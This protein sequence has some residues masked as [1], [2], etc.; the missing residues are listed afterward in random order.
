MDYEIIRKTPDEL[1]YKDRGI[2]KWQ[3]FMLPE[4]LDALKKRKN[5]NKQGKQIAKELMTAQE[6]SK[7]LQQ[8]Y[9]NKKPIAIQAN[10]LRNGHFYPDV[11]CIVLGF[12]DEDIYLS[13]KD[14]RKI[15]C[16][17][18]QIRNIEFMNTKDWYKK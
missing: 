7:Y 15:S 9:L 1:G 3:G 10:T 16:K 13:L 11:D 6:I 5:E 4:Q 12:Q 8:S 17:I 18:N 2:M 14:N